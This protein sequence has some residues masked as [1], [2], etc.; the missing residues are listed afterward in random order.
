MNCKHY[1]EEL[2]TA[3]NAS[4]ERNRAIYGSLIFLRGQ[5]RQ[6]ME[7]M[8]RVDRHMGQLAQQISDDETF[9]ITGAIVVPRPALDI[10]NLPLHVLLPDTDPE[11]D[12][13]AT[14]DDVS[15]NDP[16]FL[17]RTLAHRRGLRRATEISKGQHLLQLRQRTIASTPSPYTPQTNIPERMDASTSRRSPTPMGAVSA[18]PPNERTL[19][20]PDPFP[21]TDDTR[22]DDSDVSNISRRAAKFPIVSPPTTPPTMSPNH[23]LSS[24]SSNTTEPSRKTYHA[25]RLSPE[26]P[27]P[28]RLPAPIVPINPDTQRPYRIVRSS[29]P[30]THT[31]ALLDEVHQELSVLCANW[32]NTAPSTVW[33]MSAQFATL[34]KLAISLD[35]VGTEEGL[36]ELRDET[37]PA[38]HQLL[39]TIGDMIPRGTM[40]TTGME[41]SERPQDPPLGDGII[42]DMGSPEGPRVFRRLDRETIL[43]EEQFC[44][45]WLVEGQPI[46]SNV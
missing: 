29:S 31:T 10:A 34:I 5:R 32:E 11:G 42:V 14:D 39:T 2:T 23:E 24:T 17:R 13:F 18:L 36:R 41:N 46:V 7:N 8:T 12:R 26:L 4:N 35:I 38:V 33:T 30:I 27:D 15:P 6:M 3:I 28:L 22:D 19:V 9:T 44:G 43:R 20:Y 16:A 25:A 37:I 1:K 21:I 45:E 40:P